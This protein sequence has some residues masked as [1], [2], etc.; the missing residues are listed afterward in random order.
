MTSLEAECAGVWQRRTSTSSCPVWPS[1]DRRR[2][3]PGL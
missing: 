1:S 2:I 3:D